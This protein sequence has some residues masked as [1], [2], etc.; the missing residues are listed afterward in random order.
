MSENY[1]NKR[2]FCQFCES[3][4]PNYRCC[5]HSAECMLD[6]GRGFVMKDSLMRAL[7]EQKK[8][9]DIS[10]KTNFSGTSDPTTNLAIQEIE[11]NERFKRLIHTIFKMCSI[12]GFKL[13]GRIEVEDLSSGK[14]YK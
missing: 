1:I 9:K 5:G 10:E 6:G 3:Y 7:L 2:N 14:I 4:D 13:H 8:E 11:S 12:M